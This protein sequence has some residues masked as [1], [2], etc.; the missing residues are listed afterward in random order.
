MVVVEARLLV[1]LSGTTP[2]TL[3]RC[4]DLAAE[5]ERR[6]VPLSILHVAR[7]EDGPVTAWVRGRGAA[8][9]SVLL[10]GY[11]HRV[12]PTHRAVQLGRRA[13][14]AA[15]PAH[16]ARLRLI[17][18]KAALAA[19]GVT[20]DGFAPPR[21]LASPGTLQALREHG[22]TL[23]ADLVSVRDLVTGEVRRA[24]VQEFTSQSHRTETVRCFALV[25]AA[26]RAARRG[27]LV[28]L[29][30]DALD[31]ARPGLRQA[32]LDAIDVALEN[33]AFGSTYGSLRHPAA[34]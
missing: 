10:H 25:L 16:E 17:A 24:R 1:S 3:H 23:C 22:F 7:T 2:R 8:G 12:A 11:D 21:W 31:L 5:L 34:A 14:F 26:A 29:D 18:A 15:L 30:I 19:T 28:R 20:V 33:H 6:R 27:G 32:F 13:E 4:A 9:D